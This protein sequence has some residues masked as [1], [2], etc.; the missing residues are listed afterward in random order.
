MITKT[1]KNGDTYTGS[2]KF[3]Q[4]NGFGKLKQN[5][6]N[7]IIGQWRD[8]YLNGFGFISYKKSTEFIGTFSNG[9][10]HGIG[11]LRSGDKIFEGEFVKGERSGYGEY[12]VRGIEKRRGKFI[13]GEQNGYGEINLITLGQFYEGSFIEGK[14]SG[15]GKHLTPTEEYIGEFLEGKKHGVGKL[16]RN[17]GTIFSGK[18]KL[19]KK[20]GFGIEKQPDQVS[21]FF[22][23]FDGGARTGPGREV[24]KKF[25]YTG[26][27]KKGAYDGFGRLQT[28]KFIYI[29]SWRSGKRNGLGYLKMF[30]SSYT[31]FGSWKMDKREGFGYEIDGIKDYKGEFAGNQKHGRGFMK[32]S[33]E[34]VKSGIFEYGSYKK[35]AL[36]DIGALQNEF[37]K[38]DLDEFFAMS[39]AKLAEIDH[40]VDT[41][42]RDIEGKVNFWDYNFKKEGEKLNQ[43]LKELKLKIQNV[44]L[45]YT[46]CYKKFTDDMQKAKNSESTV[47]TARGYMVNSSQRSWGRGTTDDGNETQKSQRS[48][49]E[50]GRGSRRRSK[51]KRGKSRDGRLSHRLGFY[52]H[53][54]EGRSGFLGGGSNTEEFVELEVNVSKQSIEDSTFSLMRSD[55]VNLF[56]DES[57]HRFEDTDV[58]EFGLNKRRRA[59]RELS[60][61]DLGYS[62]KKRS[63]FFDFDRV[64]W[65]ISI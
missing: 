38:L 56:Q 16:I 2:L 1:H 28:K 52:V 37:K 14:P 34:V 19:G 26:G 35:S 21:C 12:V 45:A 18:F 42:K 30:S 9:V 64:L 50:T 27:V 47:A 23:V 24:T 25:T 6:G 13:N 51:R 29:G 32:I 3:N 22:G 40:L 63:K 7:T 44:E 5:D 60:V 57:S 65:R 53:E 20:N 43:K 15:F 10:K 58:V 39:K 48:R 41:N 55:A 36:L 59:R 46:R 8:D 33:N 61:N 31:Y 54:D 49:G 11:R 62:P 17:D 4:R